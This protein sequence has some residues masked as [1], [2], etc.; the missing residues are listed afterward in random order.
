MGSISKSKLVVTQ[1][2]QTD[3]LY[4]RLGLSAIGSAIVA[5]VMV[6]IIG[7]KANHFTISLVWLAV[8]SLVSLY[9]WIS[10]RIYNRLKDR[11]KARHNWKFRFD[12]GAYMAAI[13]WSLSVWLFYPLGHPAYQ[14]MMILVMAGVAGGAISILSY[15]KKII[16]YYLL[17]I[18]VVTD[19]RLIMLGDELSLQLAL[20]NTLYYLFVL[21]GGRDIANGFYELLVLREDT[22]EHNLTLLSATES[23]ARIGYWQW[24][25]QSANI[26]LSS[27]LVTM[28]G[29]DS[30]FVEFNSCL[31]KVHDDDRLRVQMAIDSVLKSGEESSVEYRLHAR[32]A[33]DWIIM[34]QVIKRIT[35]SSDQ[36]FLLGTVQDI[37]VIKSAEQKIFDMAYYDE[38]TGLANRGHFREHLLDQIKHV[39]RN[40]TQ[41]AV[42]FLDLDGFK[43]I[44]DTLGH[45]MG[46]MYLQ[47]ISKLLKSKVRD[48]DFVARL[49][50]DEFSIVLDSIQDGMFAAETAERCL[51]LKQQAIKVGN[52]SILPRMS[53]GIAI[54][55][56]DGE[57]ADTLLRSADAAMSSA[58]QNG[59]HSFAF[60]DAQMTAD[61]AERLELESDLRKA[62]ENNEF[63]LVYQPKVSVIDERVAG[64]EALIRWIHPVRGFVS[65]DNFIDTAERIGLINEIGEWV[66]ETASL[67]QQQWK[68]QGLQ[69]EMA[70]NVS[71]SHFSSDNFVQYVESIQQR[72]DIKDGELEIEITESMSRDTAKHINVCKELHQ[73]GIKV[74]IDD[75]GTGYSS[76]SVL[77][78]LQVNTLKV[79]RSFIQHLPDDESSALMVK[80]IVAMGLGLGFDI[81]AE[82]VETEAQTLF[83]RQLGSP[84][85]QG[86]YFSRP[87][88]AEQIP[89]LAKTRFQI[90]PPNQPV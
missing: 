77:K 19:I 55:P 52:Q 17:I 86:Y 74:A 38:L 24:D 44:N 81:V 80:A 90:S 33:D 11:E 59:K 62:L 45:D 41:L 85:I 26:E 3:Q 16:T 9:R 20:L 58:K 30:K 47:E 63:K 79:D 51:A 40:K 56:Q 73:K 14:V 82:G 8:I 27:N 67:Q 49:G 88:E 50:G 43:E 31:K 89:E 29:A 69:L 10:A 83:L 72:Y 71:S 13:S 22:E 70:V 18:L 60:Y 42:L 84:Y 76:L 78:Q 4:R 66:I 53:I 15:D 64:V 48:E 2:K 25:M 6:F 68:A 32:E 12:I 23:V 87:V 34:N 54:Y 75:F 46:D 37:S 57:D 28:C 65:P 35:D 39:S 7:P 1:S 36:L 61:A 5:M 21:K